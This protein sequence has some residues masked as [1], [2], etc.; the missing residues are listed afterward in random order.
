MQPLAPTR[1]WTINRHN[2]SLTGRYGASWVGADA[3]LL[4]IASALDRHF[5]RADGDG[6]TPRYGARD[7]GHLVIVDRQPD[8]S[9]WR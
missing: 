5:G 1:W 4:T 7:L 9:I 6:R 2:P 3:T 8:P